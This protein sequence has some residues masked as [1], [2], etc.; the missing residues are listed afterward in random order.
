MA[1]LANLQHINS[2]PAGA[3]YPFIYIIEPGITLPTYCEQNSTESLPVT[4]SKVKDAC[5]T[6]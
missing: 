1:A 2:S 3:F 5:A 6:F 4:A